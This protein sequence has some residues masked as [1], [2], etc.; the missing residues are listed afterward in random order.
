VLAGGPHTRALRTTAGGSASITGKSATGG[1]SGAGPGS[2]SGSEAGLDAAGGLRARLAWQTDRCYP[3][4]ARRRGTEGTVELHFCLDG[5]GHPERIEVLS[6]S[7]SALLDEA[8]TECV[9]RAS[10]PFDAAHLC[11]TVPVVF[12]LE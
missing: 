3:R 5:A 4:A 12:E 8:A 11:I 6:S 7:G 1:G 9:V 10:A 2:G